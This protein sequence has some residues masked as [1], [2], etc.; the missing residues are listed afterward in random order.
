[1]NTEVELAGPGELLADTGPPGGSEEP[2]S[3]ARQTARVGGPEEDDPE[4][5]EVLQGLTGKRLKAWLQKA[6]SELGEALE[7]PVE[8]QPLLAALKRFALFI[9]QASLYAAGVKVELTQ[10][11]DAPLLPLD[12]FFNPD[13]ADIPGD[14]D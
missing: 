14:T 8:D 13:L 3:P 7:G 4:W 2:S 9:P 12:Q 10:P 1:M 5:T 6:S 11:E